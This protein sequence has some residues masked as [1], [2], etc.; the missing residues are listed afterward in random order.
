VAARLASGWLDGWEGLVRLV[1]AKQF[2]LGF[3]RRDRQ[4]VNSSLSRRERRNEG[5]SLENV[6][7]EA[8]EANQAHFS[9]IRYFFPVL[10]LCRCNIP[11]QLSD[12]RVAGTFFAFLS[13][14]LYKCWRYAIGSGRRLHQAAAI[15]HPPSVTER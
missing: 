9:L 4:K 14:T 7:S 8:P 15:S 1:A 6:S 13:H 10:F 11:A 3:G 5:G 2:S 12:S